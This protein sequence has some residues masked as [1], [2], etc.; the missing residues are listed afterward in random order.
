MVK[1]AGRGMVVDDAM[2][3]YFIPF[4]KSPYN[5]LFKIYFVYYIHIKK[6]LILPTSPG[7]LMFFRR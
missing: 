5:L 1:V 6:N 4:M 3:T 7:G 2:L